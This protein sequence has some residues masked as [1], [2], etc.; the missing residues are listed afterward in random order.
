MNKQFFKGMKSFAVGL[1][2]I[3]IIASILIFALT[4]FVEVQKISSYSSY[5]YTESQFNIMG[6]VYATVCLFA[7]ISGY[8]ALKGIALIGLKAYEDE[9]ES[10][11]ASLQAP[12]VITEE[13]IQKDLKQRRIAIWT[14]VGILVLC[15]SVAV[16]AYINK[17]Q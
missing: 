14:L 13:Q 2:V 6:L 16:F 17:Y 1:L 12:P 8:Y 10:E 3:G 7:T 15:A 5:S 9:P 11:S 4:A